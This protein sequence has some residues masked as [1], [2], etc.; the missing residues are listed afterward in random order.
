MLAACRL[1]TFFHSKTCGI[2]GML[3]ILL[4]IVNPLQAGFKNC[5]SMWLDVL[6]DIHW[7]SI[8]NPSERKHFMAM[9][10][11]QGLLIMCQ[12]A[13][14]LYD[15]NSDR[16]LKCC[17]TFWRR[18]LCLLI[19]MLGCLMLCTTCCNLCWNA[20]YFATANVF[21]ALLISKNNHRCRWL[22]GDYTLQKICTTLPG[23]VF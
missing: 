17:V 9:E 1:H 10:Y 23:T 14:K 12:S 2:V 7:R 5:I 22:L 19:G 21:T 11:H 16:F 8:W 13:K 15:K 20:G 3:G 6:C 18:H 4:S